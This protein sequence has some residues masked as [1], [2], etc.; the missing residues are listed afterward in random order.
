MFSH[1]RRI[2]RLAP[3]VLLLASVIGAG[4]VLAGI[5]RDGPAVPRGPIAEAPSAAVLGKAQDRP[6]HTSSDCKNLTASFLNS[7]CHPEAPRKVRAGHLTHRLATVVIG[8]ADAQE[9]GPADD[10]FPRPIR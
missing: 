5:D 1:H 8:Q 4:S 9:A 3:V 7:A 10:L 6:S 2:T